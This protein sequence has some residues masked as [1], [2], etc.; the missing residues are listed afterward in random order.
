MKRELIRS[1]IDEV[2]RDR[3]KCRYSLNWNF[4]GRDREGKAEI[5]PNALI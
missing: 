4:A 5:A 2:E 1:V 3:S